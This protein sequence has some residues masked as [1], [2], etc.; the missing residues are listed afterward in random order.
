M[1]LLNAIAWKNIWYQCSKKAW[2]G[3]TLTFVRSL[4]LGR[5]YY[6]LDEAHVCALCFLLTELVFEYIL[7]SKHVLKYIPESWP[8]LCLR[9]GRVFSSC[10]LTFLTIPAKLHLTLQKQYL[11]FLPGRQV[12]L[13]SISWRNCFGEWWDEVEPQMFGQTSCCTRF[14]WD[15]YVARCLHNSSSC[16]QNLLVLGLFLKLLLLL[17]MY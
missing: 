15:G 2:K 6:M 11:A 13:E 5:K 3:P 8:H 4:S 14:S 16:K 1:K 10:L 17:I 12:N 7:K 9:K